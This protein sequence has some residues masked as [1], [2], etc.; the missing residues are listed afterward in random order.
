[1]HTHAHKELNYFQTLSHDMLVNTQQYRNNRVIHCGNTAQ[2]GRG[3]WMHPLTSG[4]ESLCEVFGQTGSTS[5]CPGQN[6][7]EEE[8]VLGLGITFCSRSTYKKRTLVGQNW[9]F[10]LLIDSRQNISLFV[11]SSFLDFF[12]ETRVLVYSKSQSVLIYALG[13]AHCILALLRSLH[14]RPH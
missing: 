5:V 9:A 10:I 14:K 3:S 13:G 8:F 1:M 6:A 4:R 7:L 11:G 2:H 12:L